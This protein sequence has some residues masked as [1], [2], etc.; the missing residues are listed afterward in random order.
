MNDPETHPLLLLPEGYRQLGEM[1][2]QSAR[3]AWGRLV[4]SIT[5]GGRA[6]PRA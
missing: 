6:L 2:V 3:A 1:L 5:R 4:A